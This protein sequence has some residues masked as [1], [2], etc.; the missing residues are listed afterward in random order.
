MKIVR[1]KFMGPI[2]EYW[3]IVF[4]DMNKSINTG[5][6]AWVYCSKEELDKN[7]HKTFFVL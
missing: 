7:K 1:I 5:H 2:T 4:V 3:K 6:R